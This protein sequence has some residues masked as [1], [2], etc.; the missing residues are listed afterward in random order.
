MHQLHRLISILKC[1][2]QET[3]LQDRTLGRNIISI[4][5][6]THFDFDCKSII[7]KNTVNHYHKVKA[8]QAIE[9]QS[10]HRKEPGSITMHQ[11]LA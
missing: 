1:F 9:I 10:F 8:E 5:N 7:S 3:G 4:A 2:E 11:K 6:L